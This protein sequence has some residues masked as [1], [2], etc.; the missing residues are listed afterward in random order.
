[1]SRGLGTVI[2]AGSVCLAVFTLG[3]P[4]ASAA[5]KGTDISPAPLA[6]A[7]SAT[8]DRVFEFD[9]PA[10]SLEQALLEFSRQSERALLMPSLSELTLYSRSLKASMTRSE[11]LSF[12]LLGSGLRFR[13]VAG[14]GLVIVPV[15]KDAPRV[16]VKNE[17]PLLAPK[18]LLEEVLVTASKRATNLQ[19]TPMAITALSQSALGNYRVNGVFDL[20]SL[21][22]N[23]QVARNGDHSASVLYIRG[24][25][26]DN[27]TEAGDPGIATHVDGIYSSRSQGSA[28][29]LYDL[30][31]V[32]VLRGPQGT[33]F[34]RNSTGGVINYHSNKP[35]QSL[36][37]DFSLILG[38]YKRRAFNGMVNVPVTEDW[39]LRLAGASERAEGF[40]DFAPGS[41]TQSSGARYNNMDVSAL[42]LSSDWQ[43]SEAMQ[44]LLSYEEFRDQGVGFVPL[45]DYDT[46]LLIDTPGSI[47]LVM[48]TYRSRVN[49]TLN[50]R[51]ELTYISGFSHMTRHQDW[52]GDQNSAL[53]SETNPAEYHQSNRTV[54]ADH[55]SRQH[56]L[57]LKST[58]NARLQWLVAYFNF[59]ENNGIRFDLEHQDTEGSGWGGAPSHSFQQPSR[60][61]EFEALYGQLSYDLNDQWRLSVGVRTGK[62]LRYDRGGRN[63]ACPDLIGADRNGEIGF[64]AVNGESAA[65]G[66]CYVANY[67]D[68][69]QR[70]SS[71]T[72][73]GRLEYRPSEGALLYLLFAEGFKPGIVEDGTAISGVYTGK[74]DPA[75]QVA[76]AEAIA[77]NNGGDEQSRAYVEPEHSKNLEFGFKLDLLD[78][79]LRLNGAL[80]STRYSDLQ[81]S[82][83]AIESD[84][85]E[86]FRSTN[87]AA[88]SIKGLELELNWALRQGGRFSGHLSLLDATYDHF[89]AV[90]RDFPRY[91]QTWNPSANNADIADLIDYS[92]NQLKQAP[93][94]SASLAYSHNFVLGNG[95]MLTPQLRFTYSDKVFFDEANRE[96]RSGELFNNLSGLWQPDPNGAAKDIDFQPAYGLWAAS[97]K[98][99]P[100]MGQWSLVASMDNIT[101]ELVRS[102]AHSPEASSP[103]FY[104]G[105]PRTLSVRLSSKFE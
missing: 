79:A 15:E 9:I 2:K 99:E 54:W 93:K 49:W 102:D 7:L 32:E 48:R 58:D 98:Y 76:L 74:G 10:Q 100:P 18:P 97:L 68:V 42:R 78:G 88:A 81:V 70:W 21:V 90:D 64:V 46:P 105:P 37:S 53:G 23:L 67:N 33:L 89:L 35:T 56:E 11:A 71:T 80:F 30:E 91:G 34:G 96:A 86:I 103:A 25:G 55:S 24:I 72:S 63:I 28:I 92:G 44:W 84:G 45:N 66:Q 31:R 20:A 40:V 104:L 17:E 73:M 50:D 43:A 95:G 62:D 61:S 77:L 36:G 75:F 26:S 52:D 4:L 38:D 82:G 5:D 19:D 1:M 47:D 101:D 41:F 12:L 85:S 65:P 16:V 51:V 13:E 8:V 69:A 3:E 94:L 59:E 83:V 6:E 14:Q 29:L 87:A 22:P 57:Q 27:Y 60:G 39:A